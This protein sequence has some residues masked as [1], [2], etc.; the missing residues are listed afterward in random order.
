ML[1]GLT[2]TPCRG[3]GRGLGGIFDTIIEC[4]QVAELIANK[5][6]VK[7]RHYAPADPDLK[8]VEIRAGDYVEVQLAECMD[9]SDLVGD[10]VSHWYQATASAA[11]PSAFAVDVRIPLHIRDEFL[12]SGARAAHLDGSMPKPSATP[13]WRS[14]PPA[15][16]TSSPTAW[17]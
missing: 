1:I 3:D 12:K 13:S 9:R 2:A 14:W 8:G 6:L 16:S 11:R 7:T 4:P 10:I 5:Y 15:R 17:C